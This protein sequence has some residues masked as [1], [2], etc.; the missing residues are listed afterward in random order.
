[1]YSEKM[2]TLTKLLVIPNAERDPS[3]YPKLRITEQATHWGGLRGSS[4]CSE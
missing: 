3:S 1:M 4:L 2:L